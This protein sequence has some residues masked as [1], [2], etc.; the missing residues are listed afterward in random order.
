MLMAHPAVLRNLI[1]QYETLMV[2]EAES[3]ARDAGG[4]WVMWHT[5]CVSPRA[6]ATSTVRWWPPVIS[7]R[8]P[9]SG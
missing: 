4:G 9:T 1:E 8:G 2:L 3:G 5:R 7:C 6:R